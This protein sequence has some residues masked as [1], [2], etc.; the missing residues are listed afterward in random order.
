MAIFYPSISTSFHSSEGEKL[1]YKALEK[2]NDEYRVIHSYRWLGDESQRR[3]EGE[4]DF[5]IIH[6]AKGILSVEVKAGGVA[7]H[8]GNWIQINRNSGRE[9]VMD[10]FGQAAESQYRVRLLLRNHY[11]GTMPLIGRA[12]WFT[13]VCVGKSVKLPPEAVRDIILDQ[14]SLEEPEKALDAAFAYWQRNL[15]YVPAPLKGGP[16]KELFR[17]LLPSFQI[18][19]T[20]SSSARENQTSYVQLTRQQFAVLDFLREQKIAAIHGPAGTG[21][22]LLAMEKA[23]M[24]AQTGQKVLLLCFN[25]FLLQHLRT[26]ELDPLITVHNVR[27]LAEEI[28]Q[29]DSLPIEQVNKFF[30]EYFAADFDDTE[31]HY[32]NIVVDEGQDI[33]DA[34]LEHLSF[35]AELNDGSFYVF[36]D[37]NQFILERN[38]PEAPRYLDTK[39]ECRLVLYRNCRNTAEIAATVG[40]LV[41]MR[42]EPYVNDVHGE[43]PKAVFYNDK[44][45]VRS[46]AE[47]F[48]KTMLENRMPLEDIVILSVHSLEHSA[49]H[50]VTELAGLPVSN[51]MEEGKIWVTT[52]RKFKGLEAK[53][54]LLVDVEVSKLTDA[55]M[56]RMI[57]IGGSRANSYLKVAFYEDVEKGEYREIVDALQEQMKKNTIEGNLVAK[58]SDDAEE[59]DRSGNDKAEEGIL[60]SK[61]PGTRKSV[62]KLLQME[63]AVE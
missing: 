29:D 5:L 60:E 53:A 32:P 48:V 21:K 37:R 50:G 8:N 45:S 20:I 39:A 24:L 55:V 56:Q 41:D 3:S 61:L 43:K 59:S 34:M 35:L 62:V 33:S 46:I 1:V 47:Q 36:Y 28:L 2:L 26:Q 6:P 54:V 18:A 31:W 17:V 16:L 57:Y 51:T 30:E 11:K 52:T 13:S 4:A 25:E 14:D 22:S 42:Q 38:S 23:R 15:R 44:A 12:V 49:L 7:F 19:E 9:K 58:L 27:S 40:S 10:P 63:S